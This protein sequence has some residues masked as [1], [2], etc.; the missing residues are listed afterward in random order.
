MGPPAREGL[1]LAR[2]SGDVRLLSSALD[3]VGAIWKIEGNYR[4]AVASSRERLEALA[5]VEEEGILVYERHDAVLMLGEDLTH[6]GDLRGAIAEEVAIAPEL[7]RMVPHRAYAK[8]LHP[9]LHLG[10]WDRAIEYGMSIRTNWI[11]ECRPPFAP[12]A[13][14]VAVIGF[15]HGVRDDDAGARDWFAFATEMALDGKPLAGVNLF[16]ADLELYRG[17]PARALEILDSREREF[18]W[19]DAILVKRA[20]ILAAGRLPGAAEAIAAAEA[21]ATDDPLHAGLLNRARGFL[22]GE[23]ARLAEAV[24]IFDRFEYAFEAARTRWHLGGAER[25]RALA[26]LGPMGAVPPNA[27][28]I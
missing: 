9:L 8:T 22:E 26:A 11:D 19:G 13:G 17:D 15:I 2:A 16:K 27:A 4:E 3:A 28:Y 24:E 14:D 1:D 5:G 18:W 10:E 6:I 23:P 21:R 25:E 12:L 7:L 20:E